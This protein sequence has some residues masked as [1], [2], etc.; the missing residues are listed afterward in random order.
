MKFLR[1]YFCLFVSWGPDIICVQSEPLNSG[2]TLLCAPTHK[3]LLL[4]SPVLSWS[5][6][7]L[8]FFME[9][10]WFCCALHRIWN[11]FIMSS[12]SNYTCFFLFGCLEWQHFRI[13]MN[14]PISYLFYFGDYINV[15]IAQYQLCV[16]AI[17]LICFSK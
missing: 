16:R 10:E 1:N 13:S 14:D 15:S 2:R 12:N 6:G 7:E 4:V 5:C 8:R 9:T 17:G 11:V 3:C